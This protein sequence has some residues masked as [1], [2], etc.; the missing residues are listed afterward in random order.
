MW[1][2]WPTTMI[3]Y[4]SCYWYKRK[5]D[6]I[7][8]TC[9]I[10]Y[11]EQN[12][13]FILNKIKMTRLSYHLAVWLLYLKLFLS[14]DIQSQYYVRFS[15]CKRGWSIY[16]ANRVENGTH[17]D[18]THSWL[19]QR[20]TEVIMSRPFQKSLSRQVETKLRNLWEYV[21]IDEDC[22]V[23][24]T[25]SL[26]EKYYFLVKKFYKFSLNLTWFTQNLH[27]GVKFEHF[28]FLHM[29]VLYLC[30]CHMHILLYTYTIYAIIT[31]SISNLLYLSGET[32]CFL[33]TLLQFFY[34]E[35]RIMLQSEKIKY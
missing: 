4:Q 9:Y 29:G 19:W 2:R 15:D 8:T 22:S 7:P 18:S 3:I 25:Y 16:V 33:E 28:K 31:I 5:K 1:K 35:L 24:N 23:T 32:L 10:I 17:P 21:N 30:L 14:N 20:K 26:S 11:L 6:A 34:K 12:Q 13:L 27:T